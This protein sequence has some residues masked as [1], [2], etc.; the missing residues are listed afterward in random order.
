MRGRVSVQ[1][2]IQQPVGQNAIQIIPLEK[3]F[4]RHGS[5]HT[6]ELYLP[7]D[8]NTKNTKCPQ[9]A[10]P[11]FRVATASSRHQY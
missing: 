5:S 4:P 11:T 8:R 9:N 10:P 6:L 2:E 7:T 3:D 1:H